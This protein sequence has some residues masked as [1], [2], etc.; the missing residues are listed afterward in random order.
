[1]CVGE[2]VGRFFSLLA[3]FLLLPAV[4]L[5]AQ[6]SAGES[7][8][9]LTLTLEETIATAQDQSP[10][11]LL[12]KHYFL[13]SYWE[14]RTFRS[15]MLPSLNLQGSL[16]QY[17]RSLVALQNSETGA[18]N[19]VNNNT[20]NNA[21]YLSLDQNITLTGGTVSVLSSLNRLDEFAPGNAVTYNSRPLYVR[22]TQPVNG[23]NSFKWQK[24][25][26]PRKFE[27]AKRIYLESME[28]ITVNAVN[29]FF[30][31]LTAQLQ[32]QIAQKSRENTSQLYE[33]AK[34]RFR[35]G[36]I[37]RDELLQLEL[38]LLNDDLTISDCKVS[39]QMA[40]MRLRTFLGYNESVTIVLE[41][42][43]SNPELVLPLDDV[44][45]KTFANSSATL[46]NE[47]NTLNAEQAVAKA[48]STAGFS[49]DLSLQFGLNQV[50]RDLPAAYRY[51]LDQEI[52][53]LS[54]SVPILDW[55]LGKGR[56]KVAQSQAEVV[57]SQIDQAVNALREDVTLKVMQFN[58]QGGQCEVSRRADE[59][60]RD[61]Y[62]STRDRF[63]SGSVGV[64]ELNNAQS[65]MDAASLRYLSDLSDWWKYY[66]EIRQMT[67]YD[68][69]RKQDINADFDRLA[70]VKIE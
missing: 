42:P 35:I 25:I 41:M 31:L 46:D 21:L 1:M 44:M 49:A 34:E 56:V 9:R 40:M 16:G 29:Y 13:T 23:Y 65:E 33:I 43:D 3:V 32:L 47:I 64:T 50:G 19:Y 37:T 68:Y 39:E 28:T 61:R 38:K 69:L 55:G 63:V 30:S 20:L 2:K 45:A 70:G 51:P 7:G 66:Y 54:L 53:G 11:A 52:V 58:R 14:W 24:K 57:A 10:A 48:R 4:P 15:E 62:S 8:T 17:N 22:V 27:K 36:T 18:M 67:L 6:T 5:A 12:A 59:V 26:E 60:G